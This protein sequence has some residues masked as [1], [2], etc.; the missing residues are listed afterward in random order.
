MNDLT[1]KKIF[2]YNILEKT[3]G[4]GMG[5]VYKAKDEKLDRI[6]ALKFLPPHLL[7]DDESEKRFMSEAKSASSLDHPNICTIYDIN[8]TEDNQLFIAMAFYEGETLK[9]KIDK[10][11]LQIDEAINIAVQI[12]GGL[13]L[14]HKSGIIHRDIK[15]A[16]IMITKFGE[17]KIVDFGLAKSKTSAG[18]TKFG[19]TV[20]TAAYMSPEQTRSETVDN[21]T[22]IW[23][24]GVILYEM[25]TGIT[26][27]KGEYEQAI[28]YS[29]LN[30]EL[31]EINGIPEELKTIITKATAKNPDNRYRDIREMYSS[32]SLLK[33]DSGSSSTK[34]ISRQKKAHTNKKLIWITA[35]ILIAIIIAAYFYFN[36]NTVRQVE[37]DNTRKM[38]VVLPFENL[39]SQDENYFAAGVTEEIT[40]KLAS[41]GNIGVIS[42]NSAE[43]LAKSNKS[44]E[45]IG[46][47]VGVNY[48]LSG[49][50][51]WAKGKD[52]TSRVRITPQLTR[53]SDNKIIWSNSYD[54]VLDDIFSVQNEIAQ[55][56]VDQLGG[57]LLA[58]Q[59]QKNTPTDNLDAYD[60]YLQGLAYYKRGDQN[61]S[62]I[63]NSI[64]LYEKAI[65]LDPKFAAA[66]A[67]L[68]KDMSSMYW[69]Y[70][71][72]SEENVNNA[73]ENAQKSLQLNPNLA[74]AHLALGFYYYWCKLEYDKAIKE[75]SEALKIQPNNAEAF[76]ALGYVYRRMGNFNLALQNMVKGLSLD[77]LSAEYCYNTAETYQLLRDYP[78]A[79][80]Y[81]KQ[82]IEVYLDVIR[83]RIHRAQIYIDWKGDTKTAS[84]IISESTESEYLDATFDIKIFIDV[85]DRHL[86]QA[87]Q[88]LKSS[89]INY[90]SN[91]FRYTP[92]DLELGLIYKYKNESA[93]SKTYFGSSR[94][95]LEKMLKD[96]PN[97]E[98]VHSSLGIT[99][100]GLGLIDK[101][102][103][104]GKKGIE[105]LPLE[106]EAY[107]GY[108]RQW[109]MLIIYAL[110][111]DYNNALKQIDFLL[112]MPGAFSVNQLKLDP[113]YDS[114]R[115]LPG[116]KVIVNK[117][118][119]K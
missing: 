86:D 119:E 26:P 106:K 68:S 13:E 43:K 100:A 109:D 107:R 81:F 95:L 74:E 63:Q 77:P 96:S 61:K 78:N 56:V 6:V 98:R 105:L 60:F 15:P 39:G 50:I 2:Q 91:Q 17:V 21:R 72:R 16:N 75:F 58:N 28:I 57:S 53:V 66:Y 111:D 52:K 22:D 11:A 48:I 1:G 4:G 108:Y 92:N 18:I 73:F 55:K 104:E 84:E 41:I 19:S 89:K 33:S 97:D 67:S 114:L 113:L 88:K 112:S 102:I 69:F 93:L 49:T 103:S 25:I 94:S 87:I 76:S 3:G 117:Y 85:L 12:A 46:K 79:D 27:F 118:S 14:A 54:K 23:A 80:K 115:N 82:A 24:L 9:K 20:G 65:K 8:K 37:P 42:R 64:S 36:K 44:T 35:P 99:Y 10:G 90:E 101:A 40:S 51:R 70:F 38:I 110:I 30:D 31:P 29:I 83:A 116:Y 62:N 71:D 32:L 34:Q 5:I 7:A 59:I 47:E 45:Q